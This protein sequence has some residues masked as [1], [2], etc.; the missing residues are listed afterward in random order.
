M[1]EKE[2]RRKGGK[3]RKEGGRE[4]KEGEQRRKEGREDGYAKNKNKTIIEEA[5]GKDCRISMPEEG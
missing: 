4:G 5:S 3:E 1:G 2:E